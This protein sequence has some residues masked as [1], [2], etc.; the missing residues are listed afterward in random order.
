M[1]GKRVKLHFCLGLMITGVHH[2]WNQCLW[3][4]GLSYSFEKLRWDLLCVFVHT[5]THTCS[6]FILWSMILYVGVCT[7]L[8]LY[9]VDYMVNFGPPN[10]I[11]S[12]FGS[13]SPPFCIFLKQGPWSCCF[14]QLIYIFSSITFSFS[15]S[16]NKIWCELDGS[17]LKGLI[18]IRLKLM[19]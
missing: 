8:T 2:Q 1:R 13:L 14:S 9:F 17:L 4:L 6:A 16:L 11:S 5:V 15:P 19:N 10:L 18:N 3:F 12:S 7:Y